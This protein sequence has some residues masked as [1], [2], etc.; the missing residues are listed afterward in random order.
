MSSR[1]PADQSVRDESLAV[2][3]SFVVTAPAG[4]GKTSLLTQRALSLLAEVTTPEAVLCITFTRKAAAEMRDRVVKALTFAAEQPQPES[5]NERKTWQLARAVLHKDQQHEWHLL[6]NPARLR[7]TTIDGLCRAITNQLPL[8]SGLGLGL[9]NIDQPELI[10]RLAARETIAWI[11][12]PGSPYQSG[13]AGLL[14]ALDGDAQRL[15]NLFIQ[16][17]AKRDQWL[18]PL[19]TARDQRHWLEQNI[20]LLAQDQLRLCQQLLAPLAGD[21]LRLANFCGKQLAELGDDSAIADL[22]S[23]ATLPAAESSA[24]PSWRALLK[25]LLT[26]SGEYRKRFDKSIGLLP[27]ATTAEKAQS[28]E[29]KQLAAE[30]IEGCQAI[31]GLK[32]QL[33]LTQ[34]LPAAEY[35]AEAWQFLDNLT[36]VLPLLVGH[37]KTQFS[38]SHSVDFIEISQAAIA[39]LDAEQIT[40]VLLRLDY[41]IQHILVD[42]FQDTSHSQLQLLGRLTAGWQADDG[43]TLFL[44]GDGMQS[45]YGFRGA[46]VGLFLEV[47]QNG[48]G[49][50]LPSARALNTNFRSESPIVEWVN[51]T[52]VSAFPQTDDIARGA[53][54][55]TPAQAFH[56]N[57]NPATENNSIHCYGLLASEPGSASA[58]EAQQVVAIIQRTRNQHPDETIAVLVRS[59]G[60]LSRITAAL[61]RAGLSAM[62]TEIEPLAERQAIVDLISLTRAL[63]YPADRLAWFSVLRAPWCALSPADLLAIAE[64]IAHGESTPSVLSFLLNAQVADLAISSDGKKHLETLQAVIKSAWQERRRKRLRHWLQG[65]WMSLAGPAGLLEGSDLNNANVYFQLLDKHERAGYIA[66]WE[67][68][69][70]A[71][72]K[73]FAAP[74]AGADPKLQVMTIH[75]SKGLEFD[76]V[77]IPGLDKR[78]RSDDKELLLWQSR[79][80]HAGDELLLMA[81]LADDS[82]PDAPSLY[83]FLRE[84]NKERSRYESVRLLYVGCT[85]AIKQLHLLGALQWDEKNGGPKGPS[86]NT[87]LASIW[88]IFNAT[89]QLI[90]PVTTAIDESEQNVLRAVDD[91]PPEQWHKIRRLVQSAVVELPASD[92]LAPFRGREFEQENNTPDFANYAN[93]VARATGT[94]IHR[95]LEVI[96]MRG[97]EQWTPDTLADL[98]PQISAWLTEHGINSS[99]TTRELMRFTTKL[100]ESEQARWVLSGNH[101]ESACEL[102][103][104]ETETDS[105]YIIDRTFIEDGVRWIIDYKT[106]QPRS[107]E[108]LESFLDRELAHYQKQLANYAHLF[109]ELQSNP[110][111]TALYFPLIDHLCPLT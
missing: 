41:K 57:G 106:S 16:L 10:Y 13:I 87:L 55:Y 85:R 5:G 17:L 77:I 78:T 12:R 94:V 70:L 72:D 49:N 52:F 3:T 75:K 7:I 101:R 76:H 51:Q 8:D 102:P 66:D 86:E 33:A 91:T 2:G 45:C 15:E 58:M 53:V 19:M 90:E 59:R 32:E 20:E 98:A 50:I 82:D 74:T 54:R 105:L 6:Q 64:A 89:M 40:D 61:G 99:K 43:R 27:G 104:L 36:L 11:E 111:Q 26:N 34:R 93:L 1:A 108:S 4:S 44:V 28:K 14:T 56:I 68:F 25:L 60:H 62:A 29:Y 73:L 9:D 107:D 47:Q 21:L 79:L 84:E 71:I 88:P 65:I 46:D 42:E 37:L 18:T 35:P 83:K 31:A 22:H 110:V 23:L 109:A 48:I 96:A 103:L 69:Q 81:P 95:L 63:L 38:Q 80:S 100:L 97:I 92:L 39:A 30:I 67:A 24:L